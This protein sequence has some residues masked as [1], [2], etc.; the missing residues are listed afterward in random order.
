MHHSMKK[1]RNKKASKLSVREKYPQF[2]VKI[3]HAQKQRIGRLARPQRRMLPHL[4]RQKLDAVLT[5][6]LGAAA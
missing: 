3:T 2:T 6:L 4:I 5:G 1:T